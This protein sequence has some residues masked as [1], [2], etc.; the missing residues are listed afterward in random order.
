MWVKVKN[1]SPK[2]LSADFRY[3]VGQLSAGSIPTVNRQ[4]TNS[5]PTLENL[6]SVMTS[7]SLVPYR[8]IR[9]SRMMY[10]KLYHMLTT[11]GQQS[12]D[13]WQKIFVKGDKRQSAN[14]WPTVGRLLAVCRLTVFWGSCSSLFPVCVFHPGRLCCP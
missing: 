12:A 2:S 11:V 4:L 8:S 14:S 9:I 6:T 5:K 13:C 10:H 7:Q 3:T 1:S